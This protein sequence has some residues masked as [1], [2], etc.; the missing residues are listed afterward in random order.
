MLDTV[1]ERVQ[2]CGWIDNTV[3]LVNVVECSR[4]LEIGKKPIY[5]TVMNIDI[6]TQINCRLN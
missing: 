4:M 1:N 6:D 2:M 3:L 5:S